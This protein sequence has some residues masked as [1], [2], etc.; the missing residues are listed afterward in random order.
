MKYELDQEA[1]EHFLEQ[2]DLV[3]RQEDDGIW[4]QRGLNESYWYSYTVFGLDNILRFIKPIEEGHCVKCGERC[5]YCM[6][7]PAG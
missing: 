5:D 7:G 1:F 2:R 4:M 3:I 6:P